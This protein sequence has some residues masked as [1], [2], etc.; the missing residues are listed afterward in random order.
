MFCSPLAVSLQ[1]YPSFQN[2]ERAGTFTVYIWVSY[3]TSCY[4]T[5]YSFCPGSSV[6]VVAGGEGGVGRG[7]MGQCI[8]SMRK[9]H[10]VYKS[11]RVLGT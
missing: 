3:V 5:S 8:F 11:T 6:A 2:S 4:V 1:P 9:Q 10:T 7:G